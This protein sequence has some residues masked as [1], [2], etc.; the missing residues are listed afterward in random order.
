MKPI[1]LAS[2]WC[3]PMQADV[4]GAGSL[5]P[6][7]GMLCATIHRRQMFCER[8]R[9]PFQNCSTTSGV[10]TSS[11][12]SSLKW[13]S[14]WPAEILQARGLVAREP[15]GPLARP[16]DH[17]DHAPAV[18]GDVE[19]G[20]GPV[21]RSARRRARRRAPTGLRARSRG[22]RSCAP[23]SCRRSGGAGR[24]LPARCVAARGRGPGSARGSASAP[25]PCS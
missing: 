24:I 8:M 23:S 6:G 5:P 25:V 2:D 10:R 14:S 12:G 9:S 21:G 20:I 13:V 17:G 16:A 4:N 15:G 22:A 1:S 18:V 3:R 11:P 7:R 19:V